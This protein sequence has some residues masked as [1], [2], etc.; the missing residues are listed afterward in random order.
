MK[1]TFKGF[2]AA[3]DIGLTV[4]KAIAG[5]VKDLVVNLTGFGDGI[6]D[7]T[8]SWGDW[9]SGLRDSIKDTDVFAKSVKK[10]TTFITP[11]ILKIKE[12]FSIVTQKI[13]MPSF[14]SFLDIMQTIWSVV[15]TIGGR[16]S[17]ACSG[18]GEAL[19]STFRS[20]DIS[21]GLDILNGGLLAGILMGVKNFVGGIEDSL[22]GVNDILENV[23][24]ILDSV[25]GCFEAY[26]QNLKAGTLLKIAGAIGIL[27]AS[28]LVIATIKH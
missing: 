6:L 23:T 13:K 19:A 1:S 10:V 24:G 7:V 4:I 26:Q 17:E 8:G 2:F 28:I 18:I 11:A 21:A 15:Q 9:V 3:L 5:G 25:R 14:E 22:D 20:G 27:A 16:I 12:F